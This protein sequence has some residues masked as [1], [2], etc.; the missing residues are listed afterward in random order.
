MQVSWTFSII[1]YI[2][3][4]KYYYIKSLNTTCL[5]C[6]PYNLHMLNPFSNIIY[7]A[8]MFCVILTGMLQGVHLCLSF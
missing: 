6:F 5:F 1:D 3:D 8:Y 7:F 4:T 2:H